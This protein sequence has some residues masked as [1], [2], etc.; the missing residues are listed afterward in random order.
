[1]RS[2]LPLTCVRVVQNARQGSIQLYD[3]GT[4]HR[5]S[6]HR[7][8]RIGEAGRWRGGGGRGGRRREVNCGS[9]VWVSFD[10]SAL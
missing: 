10:V 8:C 1:M 5:K 6:T 7:S 2:R 4:R 3:G 9:K